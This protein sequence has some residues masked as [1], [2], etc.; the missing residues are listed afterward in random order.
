[1]YIQDNSWF[2]TSNFL[3]EPTLLSILSTTVRIMCSQWFL[4]CC[5]FPRLLEYVGSCCSGSQYY[6]DR[7]AFDAV[8]M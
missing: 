3:F 6:S 4:S 5:N 7:D 2:T 8:G 1:M